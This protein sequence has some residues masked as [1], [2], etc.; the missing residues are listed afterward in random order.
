M[1]YQSHRAQRAI[2]ALAHRPKDKGR[3]RFV[4]SAQGVD[5]GDG[6]E[7]AP[8]R[9][10][11]HAMQQLLPGDTLYLREGVYHEAVYCSL[12][13]RADAPITIRSYPGERAVIDASLEEFQS[14]PDTAWAPFPD[15]SADEYR[16]TRRYRN[17]RDVV[18]M[19]GDSFVGLQTYWYVEDLRAL[20]EMII[21]RNDGEWE[22]VYCGPGL[23]YDRTTGHIHARLAHTH[24]DNPQIEN[25][26]GETDPRRL[27][28]IITAYRSI[29][30]FVDAA[31]HVRFQDLILR[32]GGCDV[33]KLVFGVNLEFDNVI[34]LG[35]CNGLRAK[36]TGPLRFVNSAIYGIF[37]PWGFRSEQCRRAWS[38]RTTEPYARDVRLEPTEIPEYEPP[39]DEVDNPDAAF[40]KGM[41]YY[42]TI[43]D[44][45][46]PGGHRHVSRLPSHT[47]VMTEGNQE[48]QLDG[49][50]VNHDWEVAWSEFTNSH[51]G[52]FFGGRHMR[53]H[54]NWLHEIADDAIYLTS[55]T[56]LVSHHVYIHDNLL[57]NVTI[58]FGMHNRGGPRGDIYIFRNIVDMRVPGRIERPSPDNPAGEMGIFATFCC[59]GL[60]LA[61]V[62]SIHVY[63]NTFI[64]NTTHNRYGHNTLLW[65]DTKTRRSSLN[66][67]YVYGRYPEDLPAT[68]HMGVRYDD[69]DV[70]AYPIRIDGSLHWAPEATDEAAAAFRA[71]LESFRQSPISQKNRHFWPDGFE[72]G[73]VVGN[74]CFAAFGWDCDSINDYRLRAESPAKGAGIR[75]PRDLLDPLRPA[76]GNRPDIGAIPFGG[77]PLRAG[78]QGRRVAGEARDEIA[79]S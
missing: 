75:L 5:L 73:A 25:Y 57:T 61:S 18:G 27:P 23:W 6:S 10:L 39:E 4:D 45:A 19:F 33:V 48:S 43:A 29:A 42:Y 11:A 15:G 52:V 63:Q 20:N 67:L 13:G 60:E 70:P 72:N 69:P 79:A 65:C 76:D 74:P 30:L 31:T 53:F 16:S 40:H 2:P 46:P 71:V 47:L 51:D 44:V 41:G 78:I 62:E 77:E 55:P 50:P 34:I 1:S 38:N 12:A 24:M 21:A 17:L 36:G 49:A 64:A 58:G 7:T 28:L 3:P 56:P 35:G 68:R 54:H 66:N 8:W 37:P 9:T 32:G 59:H 14:A 22:P 26:R